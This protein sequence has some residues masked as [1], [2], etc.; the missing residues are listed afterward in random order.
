[1][2]NKVTRLWAGQ[3]GVLWKARARDFLFFKMSTLAMG[4]TEPHIQQVMGALSMAIKWLGHEAD[5]L[6]NLVSRLGMSGAVP[7]SPCICSW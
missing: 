2:V 6:L 3:F 4:H 1:M 5:H 7:L